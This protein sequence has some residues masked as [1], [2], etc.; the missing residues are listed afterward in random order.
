MNEMC[1]LVKSWPCALALLTLPSANLKVSICEINSCLVLIL[2]F[3]FIIGKWNKM[4]K[5]TAPGKL[6]R[7]K[8]FWFFFVLFF[9]GG[10]LKFCFY[11]PFLLGYLIFCSASLQVYKNC[12]GQKFDLNLLVP[13]LK[14]I[15][16]TWSF[17]IKALRSRKVMLGITGTEMD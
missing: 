15:K 12:L 7:K 4:N 13:F 6:W 16:S 9:S 17:L 5:K 10:T 11:S 8:G 14:K 1:F 3:L 2:V